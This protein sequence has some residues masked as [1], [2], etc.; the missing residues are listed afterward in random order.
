MSSGENVI[1]AVGDIMESKLID[2]EV[3]ELHI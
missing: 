3:P 2:R 1:D